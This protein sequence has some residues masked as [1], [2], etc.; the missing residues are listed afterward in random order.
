MLIFQVRPRDGYLSGSCGKAPLPPSA[1]STGGG[2]VNTSVTF[3]GGSDPNQVAAIASAA[4][5]VLVFAGTSSTEG[6]D[7][8]SLSLPPDQVDTA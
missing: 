6:T 4:D 2:T 5:L 1:R 8:A 7:R 3:Y